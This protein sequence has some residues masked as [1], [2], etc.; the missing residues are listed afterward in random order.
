MANLKQDLLNNLGSDKYYAELELG[1]L[2][3]E[4]NMNYKVKVEEMTFLLK[5][6]AEYDLATQLVGK[7]FPEQQPA[8]DQPTPEKPQSSTPEQPKT[9]PGHS[10]GE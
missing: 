9:H 5:K 6:I 10:H 7:Y 2:A 3:A 8:A 1:R 4:P